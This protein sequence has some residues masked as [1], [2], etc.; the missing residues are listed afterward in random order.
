MSNVILRDAETMLM[1]VLIH[2][3]EE[4][5]T[6]LD[7]NLAHIYSSL[8]DTL[9]DP[10]LDHSVKQFH[11]DLHSQTEINL[12]KASKGDAHTR[13]KKNRE[14]PPPPGSG[15]TTTTAVTG[16]VEFLYPFVG[17]LFMAGS[18]SSASA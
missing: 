9:A 15:T 5:L 7:G 3:Y 8:R 16:P 13:T 10:P 12:E 6:N 2:H 1:H 4:L 14:T 17:T 18:A 11:L